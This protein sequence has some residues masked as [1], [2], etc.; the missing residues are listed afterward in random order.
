MEVVAKLPR[1]ADSS[2]LTLLVDVQRIL[3]AQV[4]SEEDCQNALE[5]L[6]RLSKP[7]DEGGYGYFPALL[8]LGSL[9]ATGFEPGIPRNAHRGAAYFLQLLAHRDAAND[10]EISLLDDAAIQLCNLV[11][12]GS[13]ALSADE[14]AL[15][16]SLAR[17]EAAGAAGSVAAWARFASVEVHRLLQEAAEDPASRIRRLEREAARKSAQ[18]QEIYR[19]NKAALYAKQRAE[20][21]RQQGNDACR[22]GQLPGNAKAKQHLKRAALL[23]SEATEVLSCCLGELTLIPEQTAELRRERSLLLSNEAQ[24][25]LSLESWSE[26]CKVAELAMEDDRDSVKARYRL[27]RAQIGLRKWEAAAKVVDQS[28]QQLSGQSGGGSD[29]DA[30]RLDFW[31]LAEDIS[32]MVPT[33][34]WSRAKPVARDRQAGEDFEKRI[35]GSWEYEGGSYEIRLEPWG[36]LVFHEESVKI[37]LMRKS[38]LRWRGELELISG[39]VLNVSYEPGADM[40]I[41]EFIP[42]PDVPVEQQWKGPRKFT[43]RRVVKAVPSEPGEPVAGPSTCNADFGHPVSPVET[44]QQS[45]EPTTVAQLLEQKPEALEN[46]AC[47]LWLSGKDELEGKYELVPDKVLGGRPVY[48]R[49]LAGSAEELFL[50]YRGGNWGVTASLHTSPLAA[51]FLAR[52]A[53]TSCRSKHPLD[54]RRPRWYARRGRSHEEVEVGLCINSTAPSPDA[55]GMSAGGA[56]AGSGAPS[57]IP[58]G[59]MPPAVEISGRKG[60]YAEVNG[61]YHLSESR[62]DGHPVYVNTVSEPST[63]LFFDHSHWVLATNVC[64][65]P[66]AV[67]RCSGFIDAPHPGAT[68][69]LAWEFLSDE[70]LRGSMVTTETRTYSIDRSVV[71]RKIESGLGDASSKVLADAAQANGAACKGVTTWRTKVGAEEA[72]GGEMAKCDSGTSVSKVKDPTVLKKNQAVWPDWVGHACAEVCGSEVHAT[73]IARD[74]VAVDIQNLRLDVGPEIMKMELAGYNVLELPLP[75]AVDMESSPVAKWSEKKRTLKVRLAAVT[76]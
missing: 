22:Q 75:T 17:G 62:W 8:T 35:L 72:A 38:K 9:H 25:H 12:E 64:S 56:G 34:Q 32:Q 68:S 28:L 61:L 44:V 60:P 70:T 27:A 16:E 50:W 51:P 67:A 71:L 15:L 18:E 48:R 2:A 36:A 11:K 54:L 46:V 19:Q 7:A 47:E 73:V 59:D 14:L 69:G 37:D 10:L 21:L 1:P 76:H 57:P 39:M 55:L 24:V 40:L 5:L 13:F 45:P 31:R 49:G 33:W 6:E 74:S 29:A 42:P 58:T 53:D 3:C 23:Y 43:S 4:V 26:A 30:M 52:C 20:E 63:S 66:R 65:V 41:T